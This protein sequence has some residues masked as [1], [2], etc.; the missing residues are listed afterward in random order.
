[1]KARRKMEQIA[2]LP[3]VQA[4]AERASRRGRGSRVKGARGENDTK[5]AL[6]SVFPEIERNLS[7]TRSGGHDFINTPGFGIENKI[8]KATS[9]KKAIEQCAIACFNG[10]VPIAITKDDRKDRLVTMRFDDFLPL[11][12]HALAFR[13][14]VAIELVVGTEDD[15][16]E[17][18]K[19]LGQTSEPVAVPA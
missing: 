1:M 15:E 7:Q 5:H 13:N 18:E 4:E 14:S 11:L 12:Q 17:A 16:A 19:G 2:F 8:G 6:R 3:D 9:P 10:D